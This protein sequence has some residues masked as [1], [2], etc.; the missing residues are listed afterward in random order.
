[1]KPKAERTTASDFL[2]EIVDFGGILVR[3]VDVER[4]LDSIGVTGPARLRFSNLPAIPGAQPQERFDTNRGE[5]Q[6]I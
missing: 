2:N 1:M 5:L 3:R 4:H 6:G